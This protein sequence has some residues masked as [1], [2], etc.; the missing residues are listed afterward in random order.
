MTE[1]W[2]CEVQNRQRK[3]C[4]LARQIKLS[5]K[6]KGLHQNFNGFS[7]Q[8]WVISKRNKALHTRFRWSFHFSMSFGWAPSR[9]HGPPKLHGLRGHCPPLPPLSVALVVPVLQYHRHHLIIIQC[10]FQTDKVH[11]PALYTH[12][13]K[14]IEKH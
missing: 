1:F 5:P 7:G 10:L 11:I 12:T 6:N 2:F 14:N 3:C 4:C 9:A 8:T 13:K